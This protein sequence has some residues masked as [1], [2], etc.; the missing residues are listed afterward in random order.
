MIYICA[1]LPKSAST[2]CYKYAEAILKNHQKNLIAKGYIY[3][4]GLLNSIGLFFSSLFGN[5]V[6]VKTHDSPSIFVK[7]LINL[8]KTKIIFTYRDP[9]DIILSS[10]NF[11]PKNPLQSVFN[12][13]TNIENTI[14]S[15]KKE[16]E[17]F[18]KYKKLKNVLFINYNET[19]SNPE[20]TILNISNYF[21]INISTA[22]ILTI[23]SA[24]SKRPVET[25]NTGKLTRYKEEMTGKEID[26]CNQ[27]LGNII[28]DMGYEK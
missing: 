4:F 5:N 27:I 2:I 11:K 28:D 16:A 1:G 19:V 14:M 13:H 8:T 15:V 24:F 20:N 7:L 21:G 12:N 25:F 22:D 23:I 9:R 10:I 17:K 3:R 18:Y 26:Y 6:I